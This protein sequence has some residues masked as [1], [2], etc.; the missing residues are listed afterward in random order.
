MT[1]TTTIPAATPR[2]LEVLTEHARRVAPCQWCGTPAGRHCD[3]IH[4]RGEHL[5]R[6]VRALVMREITVDEMAAVIGPLEVFSGR[7][8]IR[9]A[10]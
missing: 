2:S 8:I 6:F 5:S 9:A 4:G 7:T 3:I 10:R 1:M